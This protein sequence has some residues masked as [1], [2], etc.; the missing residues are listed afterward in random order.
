MD[1]HCVLLL[2][3]FLGTAD[4]RGASELSKV[5]GCCQR[6][7]QRRQ[8]WPAGAAGLPHRQRGSHDDTSIAAR[9]VARE[10]RALIERCGKPGM[11]VSDTGT[12]LTSNAI[13][14]WCS[15]HQVEWHYIAPGKP[16]QNGFV[17]RFNG[18]MRDELLN[19]TIFR[20]LAPLPCAILRWIISVAN[21]DT[22][23]TRDA[24][25]RKPRWVAGRS[26]L[27]VWWILVAGTGFEPVTFRL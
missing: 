26:V 10:L 11:I 15:E 18:R 14:R 2:P 13:L 5:C 24:D 9:R 27:I 7:L 4:A 6:E 1:I 25:M 12:E 17:E 22:V 8:T 23:R 3:P 19:E 20:N 16:M 21:A